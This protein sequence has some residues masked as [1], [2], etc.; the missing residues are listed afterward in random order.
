MSWLYRLAYAVGFRPWERAAARA[1]EAIARMFER[2]ERERQPPYGAA[3]DL[4]CGTGMHSVALARRGWQVTGI[5]LV[6]R[7][8]RLA[9]ERAR[10]AGVEVRFV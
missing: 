7:A 3:L 9:R 6:P 5:E 2:E 4:G 1:A 8:L 10:Q